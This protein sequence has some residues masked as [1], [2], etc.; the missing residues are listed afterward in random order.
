[1]SFKQALKN[2]DF[3]LL[4]LVFLSIT[5]LPSIQI[6]GLPA[7]KLDD[8]L[9]P[10]ILLRLYQTKSFKPGLY[11][12]FVLAFMGYILLTIFWNKRYYSI[13]DYFE[14]YK[15]GKFLLVVLFSQH[16]LEKYFEQFIW[17]IK[18]IFIYLLVFNLL[19]YFSLF[20]FNEIVMPY[21]SVSEIHIATFGLDSFGNPAAKRM[22]G[23][24]SNPNINAVFFLYFYSLFIVRYGKND[25]FKKH[26][27]IY[28]SFL[29]VLL[30][31][32]RTAFVSLSVITLFW[33]IYAKYD[34]KRVLIQMGAFVF[35]VFIAYLFNVYSLMYYTNTNVNIME[36]SSIM[37]RFEV[38][39]HLWQMI[40]QKPLF[41]H[42]PNKNYFYDN[43]LY[44][45]SEYV[46]YLWRYG[47]IG[48]FLYFSWILMPIKKS[49][50]KYRE[51]NAYYLLFVLVILINSLTNNP[52]SNPNILL[53]FAI[54]IGSCFAIPEKSKK[55]E[56]V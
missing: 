48:L 12:W 9:L 56:H 38:W 39:Q 45:E 3:L 43:Q 40:L 13:Q 36:N 2:I 1:M 37:G 15:M 5:I 47:L 35:V 16:V 8:F 24:M 52:L 28:L 32:S 26:I 18:S 54:S 20:N 22:I 46:L 31:Q 10:L 50:L 53:L 33:F 21:F 6:S 4:I 41:G 14:I 19:H 42:G 49:I 30:T 29:C 17:V 34:Y 7:I 11:G 25:D 23:T 51:K 44:A 55:I 27:W